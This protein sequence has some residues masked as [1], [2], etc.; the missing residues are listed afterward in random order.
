VKTLDVLIVDRE[1]T[2]SAAASML[3]RRGHAVTV[4]GSFDEALELGPA[5]LLVTEVDLGA[6]TGFE[7]FDRLGRGGRA[8]VVFLAS[9]P[10]IDDCRKAL[11]LGA[12]E[13]LTKPFR[14][15]DLGRAV[16]RARGGKPSV[17]DGADGLAIDGSASAD[18]AAGLARELTAWCVRK[19]LGPTLRARMASATA[20]IVENVH[21]HAYLGTGGRIALR[22]HIEGENVIVVVEDHGIGVAPDGLAAN[23]FD[24]TRHNGLARA[25]ALAEDVTVDSAPGQGARVTLRFAAYR[26]HFEGTDEAVDLCDLDHL[27]PEQARRVLRLLDED[28][29]APLHLSPAVA[30]TIGRLLAG[31]SVERKERSVLWS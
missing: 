15:D 13:F 31:P 9:R 12:L 14:L 6:H 16:E 1:P 8:K 5:G 26:V 29:D 10:T 4:A 23:C 3:R 27:S 18:S 19:G 7:L 17:K 21:R 24:S 25:A 28:C 30:V 20:E 11:L 22:A 2:A